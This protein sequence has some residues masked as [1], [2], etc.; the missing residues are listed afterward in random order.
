MTVRP[1]HVPA[2]VGATLQ[3]KASRG[4]PRVTAATNFRR[5]VSDTPQISHTNHPH[6][7]PMQFG[8]FTVFSRTLRLCQPGAALTAPR[9]PRCR[10]RPS[11][12]RLG[13]EEN[14]FV[15]AIGPAPRQ[16]RASPPMQQAAKSQRRGSRV[17]RRVA[18]FGRRTK[19]V[20][21]NCYENLV[22]VW[23]LGSAIRECRLAATAFDSA[24]VC[25][26]G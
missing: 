13:A 23:P 11:L 16:P 6:P 10:C 7:P 1:P 22:S 26:R 2:L 15:L 4:R 5:C 25:S 17:Q 18:G 24:V 21:K 20:T 19:C 8:M 14:F 9:G 3:I 12:P